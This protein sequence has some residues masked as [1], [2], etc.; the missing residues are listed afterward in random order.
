MGV[1]FVFPRNSDCTL[2]DGINFV[3]IGAGAGE[4]I[5]IRS[6]QPLI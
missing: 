5:T 1:I 3:A 2:P 4:I 6:A